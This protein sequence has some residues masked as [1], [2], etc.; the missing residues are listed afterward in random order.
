MARVQENLAAFRFLASLKDTDA[1]GIVM[2]GVGLGAIDACLAA[3]DRVLEMNRKPYLWREDGKPGFQVSFYAV[4]V[5]GRAG[6][7]SIKPGSMAVADRKGSRRVD[8]AY[9][10]GR[11]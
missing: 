2:A 11:K 3:V 7:G 1:E 8:M 6:G 4:D 10:F 9:R 5:K